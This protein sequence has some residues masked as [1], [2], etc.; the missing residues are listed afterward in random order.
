VA[1]NEVD[2]S[3][4]HRVR[5]GRSVASRSLRKRVAAGPS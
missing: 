2:Q 5:N 4:H 3:I 1:I